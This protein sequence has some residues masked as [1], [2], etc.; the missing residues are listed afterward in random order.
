MTNPLRSPPQQEAAEHCRLVWSKGRQEPL[1]A[2]LRL[3]LAGG[4]DRRDCGLVFAFGAF[5]V[6]FNLGW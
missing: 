1:L 5:F 3:P 4:G 6:F 2:S